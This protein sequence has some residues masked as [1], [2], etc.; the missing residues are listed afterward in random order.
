MSE[1]AHDPF[2]HLHDEAYARPFESPTLGSS[3]V[4]AMAGRRGVSLSGAWNFTLDLFDEGLRQH[5]YRDPAEP[6]T[7]WVRPRD[8]DALAGQTTTVPSCW[9]MQQPQWRHFEGGAW[10][11]R[12]ID[13][14]A[15]GAD[16]AR[17]RT[18]LRVGAANYQARVF[19]NGHF[20]GTH[21]GG[22]TP[23]FVDL[24][25]HLQPGAGN[26]LQIQ[27]DNRREPQRVPM[28]HVDWFN[29][30]GL[31]REVELL[32]L[33][34]VYFRRA[35]L[36]LLPDGS[37]SRLRACVE[38]SAPV[39]GVAVVDLPGLGLRQEI[40]VRQGRGTLVFDARPALWSPQHPCL[41][42]VH[43][44]FGSDRVS[45]R[46]GFREIRVEGRRILL[47][48][49]P[50]YLRGICVHEDDLDLG[51]C[52]TEEDVRRRFAHARELGCNFLRLAHYPHH[53]HVARIAD[54]LGFLLWE[55]IPV[56]W[57][58]RFED[59]ATLDDAR[60]QLQELIARD[61]NRASVILWGVGNENADTEARYA[62]MRELVR[63]AR[64]ADP[65]RLVS[66]ACLINRQAFR[67][68]DR[69]AQHLDVIGLNEYFGWY[70][71]GFEGL[72][73]LLAN[74]SPDRPVL[75][76]ETGADALAGHHGLEDELFTEECQARMYRGQIA[77]AD[78][79]DYICGITPWL[80]YDFRSERRQTVFNRGFNRK[81]LIAED[82][83]TRKLAFEV[84]AQAYRARQ[85]LE[86]G[87]AAVSRP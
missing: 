66:A 86:A 40:P 42:D 56:Y 17:E 74:S 20:L 26:R 5:W 83:T 32:R 18:V 53:E 45:D 81:G 25:E 78:T 8:Y 38:L 30:G 28:H 80:L 9:T 60:N 46:I 14:G 15:G 84:L 50:V 3:D 6:P 2:H 31:Y 35:E 16:G 10:Y 63:A 1:R 29:H 82:K 34:A 4:V 21:R 57:A 59:P 24:T 87:Q 27:V 47:N 85:A 39:D 12:L 73:T 61:A 36:Q 37:F 41:H 71:P 62:F 64:E 55:E 7:A 70:E 79:A 49:Q 69:L 23:F 11:T 43:F 77:I 65:T 72:R 54:E 52:S 22:S 13:G 68:E 51:K 19:L 48:G 76:S 58:I 44:V 75:I 33:P 67:I